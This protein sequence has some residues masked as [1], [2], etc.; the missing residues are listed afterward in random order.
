VFGATW[1]FIEVVPG[2]G[3]GGGTPPPGAW[4]TKAPT[5]SARQEVAYTN[6]NNRLY[7]AGGGT[8]HQYYDPAANEWHTVAPLPDDLDHIQSVAVGD[9]IYYVGGLA[10]WPMPHV[11]TVYVYDTTTN[12]F[13]TGTPMP[14]DRARGAGGVAVHAGK[15]YY[16]GGLHDG[17][18]VAWFD[19]YDPATG[20]WTSLPDMPRARDH[21]HAA[22]VNGTFYAIG[23]RQSSSANCCSATTAANDS[24]SFTANSWSTANAPLPTQR[25]G[26]GAA[27]LGTRSS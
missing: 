17:T 5:L 20:T 6:V 2:T 22:V 8:A 9:K 19:E 12:T 10:G 23:G 21:F 25:G 14:A 26:F 18:A 13:S 27:V 7:L 1:D 15:I 11:G 4:V 3:G 16:A 24:F